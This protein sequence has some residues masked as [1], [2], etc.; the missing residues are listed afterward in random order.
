MIPKIIWQ[1]HSYLIEDLPL[2]AKGPMLSWIENNKDYTHNYINHF[3]RESF[4]NNHFGEEWARLYGQC[5]YQVFQSDMWRI[6]C[7]YEYGGIYADMDTMCLT[8]IDSFIDLSKDF[9]CEAGFPK[10]YGWINSSIFATKPKGK[11]ITDLKN[12]I[13]ERCKNKNG[14]SITI[15]DCGPMA[16]SLV[17]DQYI[18]SGRDMS[19]I[20]LC[21]YNFAVKNEES[22]LQILASVTWNDV[23]S[24]FDFSYLN[25]IY[26]NFAKDSKTDIKIYT[27]TSHGGWNA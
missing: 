21:D 3:E 19:D 10:T 1:T 8:N 18:N 24:G 20:A 25:E 9:V 12:L 11:F 15:E 6:L 5:K 27:K 26:N 22:V 13:Y 4:I 23:K 17:M 7:L 16:F 2:F 14:E